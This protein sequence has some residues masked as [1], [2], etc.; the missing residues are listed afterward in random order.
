MR[1]GATIGLACV[2]AFG[3]FAGP[4]AA[5]KKQPPLLPVAPD[6][7]TR[8]LEHGR[9]S[10]AQYALERARSLFRLQAVRA[11]FGQV[12]RPGPRAATLILR[13][14]AL[15]LPGLSP[16]ERREARALLARPSDGGSDPEGNGWGVSEAPASP[17]CDDHICIHWVDTTADAPPAGWL[18]EVQNVAMNVWATEIDSFGFRAPK[19]DLTSTNN[20][21]QGQPPEDAG[22][23]DI[24]LTNLGEDGV[25]GYCTTDD[26]N[27][28]RGSRY[29]F[30]DFSAY[31]VLDD[32][33][34]DFG[35]AHTPQEFLKVT[36]AHEFKHASQFAYDAAED[37]WLME[38]DATWVEDEVYDEVNDNR[39][40]LS[41]SPL[42]RPG[43]PLDKGD[44][45]FQYGAWIFMRYL[46]ERFGPGVVNTI[47]ERADGS[48]GGPDDYSLQAVANAV[49]ASGTSLSS[50][51]TTFGRWNRTSARFYE[52]GNAYP[53]TPT[54]DTMTLGA[55]LRHVSGYRHLNHMTNAYYRFRPG[56]NSSTT[57]RLKV[58]LDL[59]NAYTRP[60]GTLLVFYKS[61]A[62]SVRPIGLN[63]TGAGSRTVAFGRGTVSYVDL[64]LTNASP[65]FNLNT[66]WTGT[67]PF[68]CGG[69]VP[70]DDGR[71]Y[72]FRAD[73]TR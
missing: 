7:L 40:Y 16:S 37:L 73:L 38:G 54:L 63:S 24:Y 69:A 43:V 31:C 61:G 56:P 20:G 62:Y 39:R 55:S 25:F 58:T 71:T 72:R 48:A 36:F 34:L 35:T 22:K 3:L 51:F 4:V 26:P 23:L 29:R 49:N 46:S 41:R 27:T 60:A 6:A 8:A 12:A 13:D 45:F 64:M 65:R 11:R 5:A 59:P 17:V 66:C 47:W 21:G 33:F 2:C 52:E 15:R 14:L 28:K 44:D 42:R 67:T 53:S 10:E 57:G 9:L 70:Y 19:S 30:F 1:T 50:A 68:S 32:D 18:V